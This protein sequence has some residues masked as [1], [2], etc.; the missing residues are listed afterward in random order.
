MLFGTLLRQSLLGSLL[1]FGLTSPAVGQTGPA[2]PKRASTTWSVWGGLA[3]HSPG[4]LWGAERGRDLAVLAVRFTRTIRHGDRLHIDYAA[5]LVPGAWLSMP[6][7]GSPCGDLPPGESCPLF[8]AFQHADAVHAFGAAPLGVVA[9]WRT[10][11]RFEPYVS[12]SAGLL[13]FRRPVPIDGGARTNFTVDAG[14]GLAIRVAGR[15][16]LLAG[17]K[18]YHVSNAGRAIQNPGVDGHM[19]TL[20]VRQTLP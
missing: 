2:L 3:Q 5:D 19:L 6:R 16:G 18:F 20:G 8:R 7:R 13:R 10:T 12:T 11:S 4:T 14:A 9:R 17:Y 15:W 1:T